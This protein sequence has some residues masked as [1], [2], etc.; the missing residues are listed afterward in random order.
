MFSYRAGH[1]D[2]AVRRAIVDNDDFEGLTGLSQNALDRL[3]EISCLV[4][5]GDHDRDAVGGWR[6]VPG[7]H[8]YTPA[9]AHSRSGGPRIR[10][11]R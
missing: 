11:R 1:L 9:L 2:R 7:V 6:L 5:T 4:V 8:S 10:W 3:A